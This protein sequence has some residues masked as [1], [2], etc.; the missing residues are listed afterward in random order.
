MNTIQLSKIENNLI[1]EIKNIIHDLRSPLMA[2]KMLGRY[3]DGLPKEYLQVYNNSVERISSTID[4]YVSSGNAKNSENMETINVHASIQKILLEKETEYCK[5][6]VN[7]LYSNFNDVNDIALAGSIDSFERMLSN[8]VNN[9]VESCINKKGVIMVDL[10]ASNHKIELVISDNGKGIP[11]E[12][13]QKIKTGL[14]VTSGKENGQ[15]IGF[16]Q[17]RKTIEKLNGTFNIE[18]TNDVGSK[19]SIMFNK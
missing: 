11:S 1:D 12:V 15:G 3:L 13:L 8:L 17:I 10:K 2:L 9:S 4:S 19:V 14:A 6:D 18:S 5:L 7:F 16:M